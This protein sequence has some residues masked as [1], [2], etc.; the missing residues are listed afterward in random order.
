[1]KNAQKEEFKHFG[2]DLEFLLRRKRGHWRASSK[3]CFP[4]QHRQ[5]RRTRRKEMNGTEPGSGKGDQARKRSALPL[6]AMALTVMHEQRQQNSRSAAAHIQ[7]PP[8]MRLVQ[9]P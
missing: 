2:M 8:T 6:N 4:E 1:M 5:S 7:Q 9:N 3:F